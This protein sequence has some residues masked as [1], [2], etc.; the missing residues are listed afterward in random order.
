MQKSKFNLKDNIINNLVSVIIPTYN[1]ALLLK[2]TL[3]SIVSQSYK[4]I[5]IIVVDDGSTD[6]TLNIVNEIK[7]AR[8]KYINLNR[9]GDIA[10]LRNYGV[11]YSTGEY[12]GFCDDDDIWNINKIDI[13]L[14]IMKQYSFVCTNATVINSDSIQIKDKY[15]Q[16]FNKN[17]IF[18]LK[19]LLEWNKIITSSVLIRRN[20]LKYRFNEK[21]STCSAEDYELW[22]KMSE[23]NDIYYLDKTLVSF[24]LHN[25]TSTSN[26]SKEV[27]LQSS[28][29]SILKNY[30]NHKDK[31]IAAYSRKIYANKLIQLC[32]LC[33]SKGD[34]AILKKHFIDILFILLNPKNYFKILSRIFRTQI[35]YSSI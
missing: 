10:K 9:M 11:A 13:Q 24:R 23:D 25:N 5:E 17:K 32:K 14:N 16:E 6:N 19:D 18:K 33:L 3:H 1:R 35:L 22:L 20:I 15:F 2:E 8:I 29:I 26:S 30:T 34:Y 7:D 4:N 27:I 28:V 12:I 21:N 31:N